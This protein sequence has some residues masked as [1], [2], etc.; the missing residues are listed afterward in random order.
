M[1]FRVIRQTNDAN[2]ART[3]R[4]AVSG[5]GTGLMPG[6]AGRWPARNRADDKRGPGGKRQCIDGDGIGRKRGRVGSAA[7]DKLALS[8]DGV[9]IRGIAGDLQRS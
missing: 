6:A 5:S 7:D 1:P 3:S 8:A 9:Q 4:A 2:A